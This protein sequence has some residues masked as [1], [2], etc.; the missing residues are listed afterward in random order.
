MLAVIVAL[1]P[2]L[3]MLELVSPDRLKLPMVRLMW[4]RSK[5]PPLTTI[6]L[7]DFIA[8]VTPKIKVPVL[9]AVVPV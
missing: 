8:L 4:L 3:M 9:T 5:V 2:V 1:P 7:V 6:L